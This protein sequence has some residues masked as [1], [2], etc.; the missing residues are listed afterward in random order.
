MYKTVRPPVLVIRA[1][2]V[3]APSRGCVPPC[4]A[5]GPVVLSVPPVIAYPED[6]PTAPDMCARCTSRDI[7][8]TVVLLPQTTVINES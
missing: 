7:P 6:H 4:L 3:S 5:A 2:D 8:T 1:C